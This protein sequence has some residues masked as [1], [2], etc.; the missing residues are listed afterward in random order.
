MR[1]QWCTYLFRV[2]FGV[3]LMMLLAFYSG[4]A[5]VVQ[6]LATPEQANWAALFPEMEATDTEQRIVKDTLMAPPTNWTLT[7]VAGE[8]VTA[9]SAP[10][11]IEGLNDNAFARLIE[12]LERLE[13]S[14]I[15]AWGLPAQVDYL[16]EDWP[17]EK[18]PTQ[19]QTI[20][21]YSWP[22]S[23]GGKRELV[24]FYQVLG[25]Q[26]RLVWQLRYQVVGSGREAP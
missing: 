25:T 20:R 21:R 16:I 5:Q 1:T 8:L 7:F 3:G 22:S 15:V 23:A 10:S 14:L 26:R 12:A 24:A 6:L 18:L 4:Q 17:P 2:G 13:P 9:A 11:A 19:N